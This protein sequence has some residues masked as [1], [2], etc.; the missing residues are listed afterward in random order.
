MKKWLFGA[1]ILLCL[2][3]GGLAVY[4][5]L[6]GDRQ[7]PVISVSKELTYQSGMDEEELLE[8]VSATDPEEGD[9]TG[10][11][12]VEKVTVNEEKREAVISYAA[13]DSANNIGK[14]SCSVACDISSSGISGSDDEETEAEKKEEAGLSAGLGSLPEKS[15]GTKKEEKETPAAEKETETEIESESEELEP[16]CPVVKLTELSAVIKVGDTFN[17]LI[18]VASVEDDS[19]N[20]YDLWQDIQIE[21]TY[22][23]EKAGRYELTFYVVYSAGNMSN[24]A[25][26]V[27]T[28]KEK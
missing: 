21:G 22:D 27:L 20:I 1:G 14:L 6:T 23:V 17:P 9:V 4:Q 7:P 16:G 24:R 28:V 3:L 8:G 2:C 11:L 12:V 5:K 19:D 18:Y 25:K 10:S 13:R 26:F 15:A